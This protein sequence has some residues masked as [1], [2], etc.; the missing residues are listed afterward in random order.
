MLIQD[1]NSLEARAKEEVGDR[2]D[3]AIAAAENAGDNP[4]RKRLESRRDDEISGT[5]MR[6]RAKF[7]GVIEAYCS[8]VFMLSCG[9]SP[10]QLPHPELL[11][12]LSP[13]PVT[14]RKRGTFVLNQAEE[15]CRTLNYN[16]S[17]ELALRSFALQMAL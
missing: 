9:I 5:F 11:E 12:E 15:L 17:L 10:G 3:E 7:L 6:N 8:Q 2:Y 14:P 4:L 13:L 1:A 16:V